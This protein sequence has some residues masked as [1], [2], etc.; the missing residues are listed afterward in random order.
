MAP[1]P[2]S[3]VDGPRPCVSQNS[4]S[5]ED[6][7]LSSQATN[8]GFVQV[9]GSLFLF[10]SSLFHF[11]FCKKLILNSP[12][13]IFFIFSIDSLQKWSNRSVTHLANGTGKEGQEDLGSSHCLAHI[14][15]RPHLRVPTPG[16]CLE[17][18]RHRG[19]THLHPQ[20]PEKRLL[21]TTAGS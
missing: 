5:W 6:T 16:F 13:A 9:T 15:A 12:D 21:A 8:V 18:E 10:C 3:P 19:P 14:S 20:G 2:C 7:L 17:A 1:V 4:S 11:V